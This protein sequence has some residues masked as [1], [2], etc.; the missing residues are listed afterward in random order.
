MELLNANGVKVGT[1]SFVYTLKSNGTLN[2]ETHFVPD[3]T[4]VTSLARV[5]LTFEMPDAY[6]NVTYLGRGENEIYIDRNESGRIG[7]YRTDVE[8]MFHYYVRPQSTGNRT[9]IRW[10]QLADES[11]EGLVFRSDTLFQFSVV[12]FTDKVLD[13]A[14]HINELK[15]EGIVTAHLDAAQAGVG[16]ATCGP[17]V[18]PQYRVPVRNYTFKF[19]VSPLK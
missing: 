19:I 17:G 7:I 13:D 14:T 8:R 6:S 16:T 1:A 10:M 12:P 11:G 5:G 18:L 4:V 15:R 9:D 2:I 3:T